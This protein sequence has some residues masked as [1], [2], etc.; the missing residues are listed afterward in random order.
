MTSQELLKPIQG[1]PQ[2]AQTLLQIS[3]EHRLRSENLPFDIDVWYPLVEQF[4]FPTSFI[5]LTLKEARSIVHYQDTRWNHRERLTSDN[6]KTLRTLEQRIETELKKPM[7]ENGAFLRLCGRSPKDADPLD[8]PQVMKKYKQDVKEL[9]EQGA[10][11]DANTKLRAIAR[12]NYLRVCS[13]AEAMSLLST[14][15]RVFTD[16]HDWIR[17]G[18]PEQ[19]VLR[20]W[21]PNMSMEYEFRAYV[22]NNQLNAISQY[23]HYCVYPNLTRMKDTIQEKILTLWEKVHPYVGESSYVIDFAYLEKE[24]KL[25]VIECSPFRTC[26]GAALFSWKDDKQ[27]ME[28]G[29]L[30]FRIKTEYHP[31]IE[32]LVQ[33]N[34]EDRWEWGNKERYDE[35]YAKYEEPPKSVLESILS[36]WNTKSV[37][38]KCT[39][40]F[41]Y[42]TLKRNFHWNAKF[43]SQSEF[44]GSVRTVQKHAL[45]VGDSCVPYLLANVDGG[46]CIKGEVWRVDEETLKGLDEYEGVGKGYYSRN[47]IKVKKENGQVITADAYF[48]IE[49]GE[50]ASRPFLEEYTY[51]FHKKNYK[52]INHIQVKQLQYLG[53]GSNRT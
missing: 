46:H 29:P 40:L 44:I 35:I 12:S 51:E 15:E 48:K 24:D 17:Y 8:R 43:L 16:L 30:E 22:N 6:I 4:T 13:G 10:P 28:N 19:V 42:G 50:L 21:Q 52:A 11:D 27:V 37:E 7:F 25:I 20:Q 53:E 39:L 2:D 14:S 26:T 47:S 38:Q 49:A 32:E 45:V 5:P 34:W 36:W 1:T 41:V 3:S 33:T 9:L 31:Y 18:E 23:D